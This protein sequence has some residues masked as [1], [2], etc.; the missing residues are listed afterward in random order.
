MGERVP[1]VFALVAELAMARGAAINALPGCWEHRWGEWFIA[2]NGR[3]VDTATSTD[4]VVP[5]YH[6]LV[7]RGGLPWALTSAGEGTMLG[8]GED[9]L[10]EVLRAEIGRA[11]R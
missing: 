5:P 10:C 1:E 9:E 2:I 6:A 8:G 7:E 4:A 3:G 11:G